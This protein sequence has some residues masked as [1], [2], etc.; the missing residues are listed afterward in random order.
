[1]FVQNSEHTIDVPAL[2]WQQYQNLLS[3]YKYNI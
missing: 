2:R 1:M 3:E